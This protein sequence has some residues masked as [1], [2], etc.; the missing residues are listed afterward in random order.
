MQSPISIISV[1]DILVDGSQL[2]TSPRKLNK[3]DPKMIKYYYENAEI[4]LDSGIFSKFFWKG[5]V[6]NILKFF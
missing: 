4:N 1:I 2:Q 6:L 5:G 3:I